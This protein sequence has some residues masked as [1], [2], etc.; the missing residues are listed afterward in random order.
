L[1]R[2]PFVRTLLASAALA[3]AVAL[4]GCNT[5]GTGVA[6]SGRALQPLSDKMLSQ[7]E[8]KNMTKESPILVRLFKEESELEVWKQDRT[9]RFELLKT[10]PICRWSGELG[11]KVKEG[12]RQAPEGFYTIMPGQMNPNSH[13][14]LAINVGYPN[15]FDRAWGRTG[16]DVM[17]HGD[18]SS[19]GCF[20]MTDEQVGEIYALARESFFGGQRSFQV[21]SYPF[22]M[23]PINMAKHRNNPAMPFWKE[24]KVGYDHFEV[25]HLEPRVDVCDKHYVF[26]A[27]SRSG[28]GTL[29]FSPKGACPAYKVPEE[30]ASAVE[31][32]QRQDESQTA[33]LVRRGTPTVPVRM[34]TDGGMN[35]VFVAALQG[36]VLRDSEGNIRSIMPVTA[37]G[38]IPPNVNPPH[39]PAPDTTGSVG[40][41]A[42]APASPATPRPGSLF[43]GATPPASQPARTQV[44]TAGDGG[45][46]TSGKPEQQEN[47]FGRM[48]ST[49][50]RW[51]G[52]GGNEGPPA[53]PK[54]AKPEPK[55]AATAAIRPKPKAVASATPPAE[56][57]AAAA[58]AAPAQQPQQQAAAAPAAPAPAG[59]TG[60]VNP[61]ALPVGSFDSRW[62][63]AR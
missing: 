41:P 44:A 63:G 54:A 13:Y 2:R 5:D 25:T 42:S 20:A 51:V 8:Q 32:K 38:T 27:V 45:P 35:P 59:S 50:G 53:E 3:A 1:H 23:T 7:I 12:D 48:T 46:V 33:E 10:Y 19:R 57:P 29:N 14:Y 4:A 37:P 17:V 30:I 47:I 24:I 34:G 60:F 26:D 18:C 28:I 43:A 58:A 6:L 61:G 9:G 49:M 40:A 56:K 21:Q 55:P 62:G 11:P 36:G 15:A 22:H 39:A 52:L 16:G 31:E